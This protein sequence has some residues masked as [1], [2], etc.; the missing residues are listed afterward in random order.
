[1]RLLFGEQLSEALVRKLAEVFPGAL[2]V[3]LLDRG[4]AP[5]S[6]VWEL[7][8]EHGCVLLTKDGDFHA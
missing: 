2:H 8:R 4:G 5:D 1:M 7:A 3:R 6:A